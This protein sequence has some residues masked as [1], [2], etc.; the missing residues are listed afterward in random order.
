M[1]RGNDKSRGERDGRVTGRLRTPPPGSRCLSVRLGDLL[2]LRKE[3]V[4]PRNNPTGHAIF[5]GL[6]HIESHSGRRIGSLELEL[7]ELTGRKPGYRRGDIVYGYLRPYLNKVWVAE[8]DGLCSVDQYVYEVDE[9]RA[10]TDYVAWFMRS[11]A[12]LER[13]PIKQTPGQLPRIRT[14]EVS[15]V[16]IELPSLGDQR[17]TASLLRE[18]MAEVDGA[19]AAVQTQLESA[20]LFIQAVLRESLNGPGCVTVPVPDCLQEVTQGIGE[21]W[22][23]F[24]VLGATR[25]GLAPAKEGV[26]KNPGRYKPVVPGTIF[27]NPMRILLG[28]IAMLDDGDASGITSPDYVVMRGVEGRLHPV[29]F[30]HWFRSHYGAEFILSLTR[31]AV[32]ERLLFNRLAKASLTIPAWP[33]QLRAVE[34]FRELKTFRQAATAR[35]ETI[36]LLPT[37]LLRQ[38]FFPA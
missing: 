16:P 23:E 15:S 5:V 21:R 29:W 38:A 26:G 30:Y 37:A 6:E 35:L 36:A 20:Q 7:A 1:K 2:H 19:R 18:Q 22:S 8:F 4:H 27:Y 11:P 13:A 10:D 28:S 3:V 33:T 34:Q 12:Y 17:R 31:G 14:E 32:R 9:S 25:A 24:P